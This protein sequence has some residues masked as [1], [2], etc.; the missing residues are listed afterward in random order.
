M[1]ISGAASTSPPLVIPANVLSHIRITLAIHCQII[2]GIT[3]GALQETNEGAIKLQGQLCY[4]L[5]DEFS[6]HL[7]GLLGEREVR[8]AHGE[9]VETAKYHWSLCV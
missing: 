7:K 9:K 2:S 4:Q 6:T 8:C 3:R 5:D 1:E